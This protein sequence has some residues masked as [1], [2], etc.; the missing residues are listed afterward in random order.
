MNHARQA[1]PAKLP[2]TR[3]AKLLLQQASAANSNKGEEKRA[4]K[5]AKKDEGVLPD[6]GPD[7]P[8]QKVDFGVKT[9]RQLREEVS[10]LIL[11]VF[12]S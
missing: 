3:A 11:F 7:A 9:L 12:T 2:K 1:A 8:I 5:K 6:F 10:Y 4:K